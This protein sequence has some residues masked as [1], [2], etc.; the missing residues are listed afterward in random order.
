[1][2]INSIEKGIVIDHLKAGNGARILH[3]L[4]IDT[5]KQSVAFLMNATSK[6][7]GKK[8][9]IKIDD[10]TAEEIDLAVLGLID[11]H[12]TV[13]VIQNHKIVGKIKPVMPE[14][15]KNVIRCRNPRCVTSVEAQVPHIFYLINENNR[16]YRC[17]YCDEIISMKKDDIAKI[18]NKELSGV[19]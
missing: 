1:M 2:V 11:P 19:K 12:C 8:D 6:Q 16:E 14:K 17:E 13:N 7:F 15:I 18:L 4:N 3:Y 5:E 9:V 10:V